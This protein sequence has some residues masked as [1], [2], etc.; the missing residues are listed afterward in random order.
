MGIF[1]I[2]LF[3]LAYN[4]YL[5]SHM[6]WKSVLSYALYHWGAYCN[7]TLTANMQKNHNI[8]TGHWSYCHKHKIPKVRIWGKK[9]KNLYIWLHVVNSKLF[10]LLWGFLPSCNNV[11]P[12]E[13]I[14]IYLSAC[15]IIQ[16]TCYTKDTKKYL[17]IQMKT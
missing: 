2:I 5:W 13:F 8:L 15:K 4:L 6:S 10:S 7:T 14:V 11:A 3:I 12:A 9:Y 17:E 16:K 1:Y